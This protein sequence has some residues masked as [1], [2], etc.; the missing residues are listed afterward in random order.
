MKKKISL[1]IITIIILLGTI[2]E[3]SIATKV[4]IGGNKKEL[5]DGGTYSSAFLGKGKML[6]NK[7]WDNVKDKYY[8]ITGNDYNNNVDNSKDCLCLNHKAMDSN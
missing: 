8:T 7:T 3:I 2:M 6:Y 4:T 1:I 5:D